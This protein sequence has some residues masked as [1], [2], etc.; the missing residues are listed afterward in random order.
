MNE[1]RKIKICIFLSSSFIKTLV[2][3][4]LNC[5]NNKSSILYIIFIIIV[6]SYLHYITIILNMTVLFKSVQFKCLSICHSAIICIIIIFVNYLASKIHEK[7]Y[8]SFK[9]IVKGQEG[10][11]ICQHSI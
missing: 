10:H 8:F 2:P 5:M 7:Y 4:L 11:V 6:I 1:Y 9:M 3:C